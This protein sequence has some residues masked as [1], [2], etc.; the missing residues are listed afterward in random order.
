MCAD[1]R[2]AKPRSSIARGACCPDRGMLSMQW[3]A[4]ERETV[5]F[6][7]LLQKEP[8]SRCSD[9]QKV[10]SGKF[11]CVGDRRNRENCERM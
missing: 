6:F 11:L 4:P 2:F 7:L 3:K 8:K 9:V 1:S 5:L 10:A